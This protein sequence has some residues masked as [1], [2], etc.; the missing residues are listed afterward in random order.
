MEKD[1]IFSRS[2]PYEFLITIY[3]F[4]IFADFTT[5]YPPFEIIDPTRTW[6]KSI[7]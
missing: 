3:R 7:S 5:P 6:R 4:P 2:W 1:D